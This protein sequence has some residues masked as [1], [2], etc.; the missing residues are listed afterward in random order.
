MRSIFLKKGRR[1][2]ERMSITSWSFVCR[3]GG[4]TIGGGGGQIGGG[5]RSGSWRMGSI[6][7][8]GGGGHVRIL[9]WWWMC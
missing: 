2:K 5:A 4:H 8:G 3:G 9:L 7:R 1:L 6:G